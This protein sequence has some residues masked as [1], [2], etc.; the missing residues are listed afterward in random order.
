M[1]HSVVIRTASIMLRST[2]KQV[3]TT[4]TFNDRNVCKLVLSSRSNHQAGRGSLRLSTWTLPASRVL[5]RHGDR[6]GAAKYSVP[7]R[8]IVQTTV[9]AIRFGP[10]RL[11][12][13]CLFAR[14]ATRNRSVF[15]Y[16]LLFS[17][18]RQA[19]QCFGVAVATAMSNEKGSDW[20]GPASEGSL[21]GPHPPWQGPTG[22]Q[23]FYV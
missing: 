21:A 19:S 17:G 8:T 3:E 2:F 10:R 5:P 6:A 9:R 4:V 20:H 23:S 14:S 15:H 18:V 11:S 7:P 12:R 1:L 13:F 22:H 16:I